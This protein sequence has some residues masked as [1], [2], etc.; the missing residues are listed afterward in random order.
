MVKINE[1]RIN[2]IEFNNSIFL[3]IFKN[4]LVSSRNRFTYIKRKYKIFINLNLISIFFFKFS[5]F[6][7]L[8]NIITSKKNFV[9]FQIL[10]IFL[11]YYFHYWDVFY[12]SIYFQ[13]F[14]NVVLEFQII[15]CAWPHNCMPFNV[16]CS[17]CY[18]GFTTNF[19]C[20][21]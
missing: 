16:A 13:Y 14:H 6:D 15:H 8:I 19:K 18:G 9:S 17:T 7:C 12:S 3:T 1:I 11:K 20:L 10:S 4:F 5:L 21:H 2:S